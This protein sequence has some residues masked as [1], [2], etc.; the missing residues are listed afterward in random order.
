MF[1]FFNVLFQKSLKGYSPESPVLVPQLILGWIF[2]Y[3][4]ICFFFC[5]Y[6]IFVYLFIFSFLSFVCLFC[7]FVS[8][9]FIL[10]L[11]FIGLFCRCVLLSLSFFSFSQGDFISLSVGL[12]L[13]FRWLENKICYLG[14]VYK[15]L[16]VGMDLVVIKE[17]FIILYI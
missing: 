9:L 3:L 15:F 5:F 8:W 2:F 7:L 10:F 1:L 6:F 13:I 14:A 16:N 12:G 4:F 17:L 11:F